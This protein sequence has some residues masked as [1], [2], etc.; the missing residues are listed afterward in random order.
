MKSGVILL[1]G[2]LAIAAALA[3][4]AKREPAPSPLHAVSEAGLPGTRRRLPKPLTLPS[5][6]GCWRP[7]TWPNTLT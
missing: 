1:C 4:T 2:A 3:V 5:L 6:A 7:S